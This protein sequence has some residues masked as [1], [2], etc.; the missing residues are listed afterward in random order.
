MH[1]P[2]KFVAFSFMSDDWSV[3]SLVHLYNYIPVELDVHV[4]SCLQLREDDHCILNVLFKVS[5][6]SIGELAVLV[7]LQKIGT[8]Q[9]RQVGGANVG[10]ARGDLDSTC[11]DKDI[12]EGEKWTR[13][14][15][16]LQ[17]R[18]VALWYVVSI[19]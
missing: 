8:Q 16:I 12:A 13:A 1:L 14:V 3:I 10:V 9:V 18:E 11:Q 19:N 17:R 15:L 2:I 7:Q 4:Q 6:L 5:F